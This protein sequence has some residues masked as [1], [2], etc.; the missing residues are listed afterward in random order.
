[1]S[2]QDGS[3]VQTRILR[4]GFRKVELVEDFVDSQKPE[5]GRE[6]FF[7]VNGVQMYSKGSNSIPLHVLPERITAEQTEW[8]FRAAKMS[9]Q[10]IIRVWGGGM[11]ETEE[12]YD[13]ADEYGVFIW[14]D[15][16]FAVAMY[17][18][19]DEFLATVKQEVETQVKRLQY[20]TSLVLW[21]GNNENEGALRGNWF[22]T[23]DNFEIYKRDYVKLYAET[24]KV[25]V[26]EL[27]PSRQY[28]A[29]SPTNGIRTEEEGWVAEDPYSLI[30]GDS[31]IFLHFITKYLHVSHLIYILVSFAA[32]P[33]DYQSDNWDWRMFRRTRFASEYGYQ[34]FPH[35]ETLEKVADNITT[36]SWESAQMDHR[37]RHAG[38]QIEIRELIR[39]HLP[40]PRDHDSPEAL[41]YMLYMAQLSQVMGQKT[42]TESY[43]RLMDK[44]AEDGT[45]HNM[46]AQYWQLN[47]I[48]E[49]CSWSSVE[50]NGKWKLQMYYA[51]R[52]FSPVLPSPYLEDGSGDLVVEL[53]SD[54]YEANPSN[55]QSALF[56]EIY[57]LSSMD[58]IYSERIEVTPK[59]L[60]SPEV[61]RVS[62]DTL[63]T[64][65]CG[66]AADSDE[67]AQDPCFVHVNAVGYTDNFLF[68]HYP[69]NIN[70]V[71]D[72][73]L[74]VWL[75]ISNQSI[76]DCIGK[77]NK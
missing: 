22:G 49:G 44:M 2:S 3:E 50:V 55:E 66:A 14:E 6:F 5:M 31:K 61:H 58:T 73:N 77:Q 10:N 70:A 26:E 29:S 20:R 38:G 75:K 16:Q 35:Y 69:R 46:G 34:S 8:L 25:L 4:I 74:R 17:P 45:G 42:Q 21:A 67:G 30:Y 56:I 9:H 53:I 33:Y 13:L 24:I 41:P 37:Q 40:F 39:K 18:A 64:L 51:I 7:R 36:W 28:I 65:G 60:R 43:R 47:D 68:L 71:K 23:W 32:H 19:T 76:T 12:F 27:D 59:F 52:F 62:S 11:Y 1:M 72:P 63:K 57:K 48:W 54:L 15:F